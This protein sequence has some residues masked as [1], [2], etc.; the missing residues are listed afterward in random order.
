MQLLD[1]AAKRGNS[2]GM[3]NAEARD[4]VIRPVHARGR[5]EWNNRQRAARAAKIL[6][7]LRV[8]QDPVKPRSVPTRLGPVLVALGSV[9]V[10]LHVTAER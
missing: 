9:G 7:H 6:S 4:K 2:Q 3:L 5:W 10:Y 1:A 8:R